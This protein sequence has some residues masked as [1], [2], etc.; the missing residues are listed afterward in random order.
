[1]QPILSV[2]DPPERRGMR[3]HHVIVEGRRKAIPS[4]LGLLAV[5]LVVLM[6]LAACETD[7]APDTP[8]RALDGGQA[9]NETTTVRITLASTDLGVSPN[10]LAFGLVDVESGPIREADVLISTFY[11][12]D[13]RQRRADTDGT[14]SLAPLAHRTGR[15][16]HRQLRFRPGGRLGS[17]GELCRSSG[18][19]CHRIRRNRS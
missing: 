5:V 2:R 3:A 17:G 14:G 7:D 4:L 16:V 18:V 15:T 6:S 8:R 1:M 9:A 11:L 19:K 10:R 13:G 12:G